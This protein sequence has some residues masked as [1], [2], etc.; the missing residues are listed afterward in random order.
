MTVRWSLDSLYKSFDSKE[1]QSDLVKLEKLIEEMKN[2]SNEN[3]NSQNNAVEKLEKVIEFNI[4]FRTLHSVMA[5]FSRL[6]SSVDA[7]NQEATKYMDKLQKMQSEL[8]APQV[9]FELWLSKVEDLEEVINSSELLKEHKFY[10]E[11]IAQKNEYLLSEEE[12]VIISKMKATGSQAW[13]TLQ[14]Q[15]ISTHLVEIELDGEV[16]QLPL[17]VV[18]NMAHKKEQNIRKKAYEAELKSYKKIEKGSA[19]CLNGIKGEVITVSEL[20]GY[21]SPLEKTLLDSRMK[22]ETLDAMINA[23]R[24]YLPKFHEYYK[25]KAKILG[26]EKGLPFYE[27]FAPVGNVDME[28]TFDEAREFIVSNFRTFTDKLADF[29]DQAFENQ[30]I[31]AE[32]RDG[33]RGGAFC[34]N[35]VAIKESRVLTNYSN[36]LGSV[37]TLAHELGHAYHGYNLGEESILNTTYPMPLAETASIFN[38]SIVL[39]AAMKEANEEEKLAILNTQITA[40]TQVTV[41]IL[42]RFI[43]ETELFKRREDHALSVDELKEI[44]LDAQ[45]EA[46]GDGLDHNYLHPYMWVNKP[47]YYYAERNF[48]NFPYAFGLLFV[49]GL[50]AEYLE[51][52]DEFI[53][54]YDQLLS[55]TGKMTI[56]D[57]ASTVGVDVTSID[58]WRSSLE[59]IAKDVDKFI[60]LSN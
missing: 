47:H 2:W 57:A 45:K 30:W 24:E 23:I 3:L 53:P 42:S 51:V 14:N 9:Q 22:Q 26:H 6:S 41:D 19:A 25:Q 17:P 10:I 11:E 5:S 18:R 21:K 60:D 13:A 56:E 15:L 12:E 52:G 36:S 40:A 39:N 35:I 7:N 37:K 1:F 28:F 32:M 55:V 4:E 43:F 34:N 8:T 33:K 38:E 59:M 46:Y 49:K 27:V 58:F 54:K 31:D 50:Y 48:Y 20:K 29:T 44:M 16:R